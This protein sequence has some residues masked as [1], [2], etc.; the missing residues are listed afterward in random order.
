[1]SGET[2]TAAYI[3]TGCGIG[4]K[5]DARQLAKVAQR[6]GKMALVREHAFLCSDGGVA[7]IR[8]DIAGEG[9]THAAIFSNLSRS[10]VTCDRAQSVPASSLRISC[11][12]TNEAAVISTRSWFGRNFMQL[13]RSI[14]RP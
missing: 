12:S 1:M 3:C 10:V 14:S 4:D 13:V 6:E 2:K 8:N 5:L 7:T 9:V 11:I